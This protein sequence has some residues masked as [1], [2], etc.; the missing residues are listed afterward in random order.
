[1]LSSE[2]G[3]GLGHPLQANQ[4]ITKNKKESKQTQAIRTPPPPPPLP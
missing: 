2:V 4:G 1:M 3:L